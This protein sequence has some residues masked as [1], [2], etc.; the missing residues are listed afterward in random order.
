MP[1]TQSPRYSPSTATNAVILGRTSSL[2]P[3]ELGL[4]ERSACLDEIAG[5][6]RVLLSDASALT[7]ALAAATPNRT[8][9]NAIVDALAVGVELLHSQIHG[10]G[11]SAPAWAARSEA[12]QEICSA[13][14]LLTGLAANR[15]ALLDSDGA[16]N[17]RHFLMTRL[18]GIARRASLLS[19]TAAMGGD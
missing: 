9:A 10:L 19:E 4:E 3:S 13:A 15:T 2:L 16:E 6:A 5:D 14:D 12:F 8:A 18:K 7:P 11:R 17:Y 1:S